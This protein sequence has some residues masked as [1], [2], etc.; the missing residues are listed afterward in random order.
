MDG[1]P[2]QRDWELAPVRHLCGHNAVRGC[3]V[4]GTLLDPGRRL[5]ARAQPNG[6]A[7]LSGEFRDYLDERGTGHTRGAPY[8]P[9]AQGKIERYH[10]TMKK[11]VKLRLHYFPDS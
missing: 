11:V 4:S 3:D 8:H 5:I 10:R 7:Y 9:Q 2:C 1:S 6:P